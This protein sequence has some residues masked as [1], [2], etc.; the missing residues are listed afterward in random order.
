M[1]IIKQ[2]IK[3]TIER[4]VFK[5]IQIFRVLSQNTINTEPIK[6]KPRRKYLELHLLYDAYLKR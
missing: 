3:P 2:K 1:V 6:Y 4:F 5:R